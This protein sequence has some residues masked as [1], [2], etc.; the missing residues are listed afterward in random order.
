M[1]AKHYPNNKFR[2]VLRQGSGEI[3]RA[4]HADEFRSWQLLEI[5]LGNVVKLR[6]KTVETVTKSKAGGRRRRLFEGMVFN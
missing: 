4:S 3:I 5:K 2:R 6:Q 1:R